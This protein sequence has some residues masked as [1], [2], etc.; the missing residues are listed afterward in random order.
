M[1]GFLPSLLLCT[2]DLAEKFNIKC[3]LQDRKPPSGWAQTNLQMLEI[4]S[5]SGGQPA[6][7]KL[8]LS[9]A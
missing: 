3:S 2:N 1:L 4:S 5:A 8:V 6:K 7:V 9:L